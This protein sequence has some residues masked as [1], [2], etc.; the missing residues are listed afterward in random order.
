LERLRERRLPCPREPLEDDEGQAGRS[1]KSRLFT[2]LRKGEKELE[3]RDEPVDEQG[4]VAEAQVCDRR[5][6]VLHLDLRALP[7][8]REGLLSSL[9][10]VASDLSPNPGGGYGLRHP[11][12]L[13]LKLADWYPK[14]PSNRALKIQVPTMLGQFH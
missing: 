10:Y 6:A 14:S 12:P 1:G 11:L 13:F 8:L 9:V 7:R 4:E 5:H 2:S 3:V